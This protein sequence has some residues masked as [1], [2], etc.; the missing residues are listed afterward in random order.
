MA[1]TTTFAS[2]EFASIDAVS[3]SISIN[4]T[5]YGRNWGI[6]RIG[7]AD[8][9]KYATGEGIVVAVLDSGIDYDHA[10]LDANIWVNDGEIAGDGI[11]NDGNGF[12]DDVNGWNFSSSG[13]ANNINDVN[14]HGTHVAG[15]IAA[16]SNGEGTVGVAPDAE[17][18]G[19][20]VLS[21][22]GFGGWSGIAQGIDYAVQNGAKIINMS[23]GGA[24]LSTAVF[25]AVARAQEAGVIVVAAAGN[26][27]GSQAMNPA[28]LAAQFDNVISVANS[29]TNDTLAGNSNYSIDGTTVDLAAPG[30]GIR[31]TT[32]NDNT[33]TKSGT[34]MA[35]PMVSGAAAVLWSAAPHLSYREIIDVIEASVDTLASLA[36][37]VA[38][39]GIL[40]LAEAMNLLMG[41]REPDEPVNDAPILTLTVAVSELAEDMTDPASVLL[42]DLTVTDDGVGVAILELTGGDVD[43]FE[44][45]DG[46]LYLRDG[47][48]LDF[49]TKSSY[50]VEISVDDPALGDGPEGTVTYTLTVG[51]VDETPPAD[52][53][54]TPGPE[55]S[56]PD[57]FAGLNFWYDT[58]DLAAGEIDRLTDLSGQAPDAVAGNA[59][60]RAEQGETGLRFD[61]D[62]VY[63]IA[64]DSDLN[65]GSSYTG[66]TLT[67]T[68][69]T[70]ADV[71]SRQ[72]LF[73]QGGSWRGLSVYVEGGE[74]VMAGWNLREQVWGVL[75]VSTAV[76]AEERST[77]SLVFDSEAGT[78][79]GWKDGALFGTVDGAGLLYQ[80]GDDIGLGGVQGQ[81]LVADGSVVSTGQAFWQGALFEAAGHGRALTGEE[82]AALHAGLNGKWM[83]DAAPDDPAPEPEPEP[84]PNRGPVA[85]DDGPFDTVEGTQV[86]LAVAD[87]LANDWD[88]DGDVLT[89]TG[90]VSADGGTAWIDGDS[91]HFNADA[92]GD[93]SVVYEVSDGCGGT[94]QATVSFA[95]APAP[96]PAPDPAPE[97]ETPIPGP[98]DPAPLLINHGGMDLG[99]R[100]KTHIFDTERD[101]FTGS[102]WI[103]NKNNDP[104]KNGLRDAAGDGTMTFSDADGLLATDEFVLMHELALQGDRG[105][106]VSEVAPDMLRFEIDGKWSTDVAYFEGDF[107]VDLLSLAA[108]EDWML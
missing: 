14:S 50:T 34:S 48:T 72:M 9:W 95:V 41:S 71:D 91:F 77:I 61:G 81:T 82:L 21:D 87:L 105:M 42:A 52:P 56:L 20:K 62:D 70:G 57:A 45:R 96:A 66:K 53:Q 1:K 11:D 26:N 89:L 8:A 76:A 6:D 7:A 103:G 19:V 93:A 25:N 12:I 10:D 55:G 22:S 43:A 38:T 28:A 74:I 30:T 90:I 27:G 101:G 5:E 16:E 104:T 92:V 24:T 79:S 36:K 18:M 49:E 75:S 107:V 58:G 46:G 39:N 40:N 13:L 84:E 33:G 100:A 23:L 102:F 2:A 15:I 29:T 106:R 60:G 69:E 65:T 64:D 59:G 51:D 47:V 98:D 63:R 37:P 85:V 3:A 17:I 80:H 108:S 83:Q 44:I 86:T 73:E 68:L 94:D 78:F 99:D 97:P 4:L 67:F 35:A 88:A 31:S 32:P 54:P